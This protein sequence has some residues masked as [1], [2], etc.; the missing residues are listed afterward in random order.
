MPIVVRAVPQEEYDRWYAEKAEEYAKIAQCVNQEWT[1]ES[2]YAKGE[3]VYTAS[4]ASCHQANGAGIPPAFPALKG[5][6]IALGPR[7]A[8]IDI[9]VNGKVGTAMQAFGQQLDACSIA[10]VVHYERHAWG[11]N[12]NDV[13]TP[14]DVL[15]FQGK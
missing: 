9:I 1:P 7:E 14:Q 2:L 15:A 10:A 6:A 3:E 4:C 8:H 5:S 12:T 13:T 11:N